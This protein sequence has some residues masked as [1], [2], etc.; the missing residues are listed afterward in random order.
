MSA[1]DNSP[2]WTI[3]PQNINKGVMCTGDSN[4]Y[5]MFAYSP[6]LI[7]ELKQYGNF[8][9]SKSVKITDGSYTEEKGY[10]Q[11]NGNVKKYTLMQL[12]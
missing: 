3:I 1:T 10:I 6:A 12:F 2:K 11:V 9:E 4:E 5:K 7:S 8:D